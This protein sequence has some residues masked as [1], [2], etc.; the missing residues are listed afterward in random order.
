MT[1]K[2]LLV[3]FIASVVVI[4]SCHKSNSGGG[5]GQLPG[6]YKFLY[7]TAQ[8]Q[9]TTQI[10]GGGLNEKQV[11]YTNFTTTQNTGTVVITKDSIALKGVGYTENTT[12]KTYTYESGVLTDSA[13]LPYTVPVPA[14]DEGSKYSVIGTDSIYFKG[15]GLV[16]IGSTTQIAQPS[17]G[18]FS[19]KG[20]SL[21]IISKLNQTTS[22]PSG[23]GISGSVSTSAVE[24]VV[25]LKQ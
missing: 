12:V 23:G 1:P 24:T 18:R 9:S 14:M 6:T 7:V 11:S 13:S 15:G 8:T 4:L 20:D 3:L 22:V 19:F 25:L 16:S 10:S 5:G 2:L 21:F 17:G